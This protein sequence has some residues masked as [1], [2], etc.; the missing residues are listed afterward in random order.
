[1]T[2]WDLDT[3]RAQAKGSS[4]KTRDLLWIVEISLPLRRYKSRVI[5]SQGIQD[6]GAPVTQ[7]AP[8]SP[9]CCQACQG[10][11]TLALKCERLLFLCKTLQNIWPVDERLCIAQTGIPFCQSISIKIGRA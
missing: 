4:G 11:R 10:K 6:N 2:I 8:S 1:M 5:L 9:R 7:C 3:G